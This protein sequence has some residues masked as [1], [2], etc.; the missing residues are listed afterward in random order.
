MAFFEQ[1]HI[2]TDLA[3]PAYDLDRGPSGTGLTTGYFPEI[4]WVG[5]PTDN[6]SAC[7][8]YDQLHVNAW[9]GW[10]DGQ[11]QPNAEGSVG[12]QI[13]ALFGGNFQSGRVLPRSSAEEALTQ[14]VSVGQKTKGYLAGSLAFS[15]DLE[16]AIDF[17]DHSL[18][19]VIN[20]LKA[21]GI[22]EDT[23]IIVASKHG[24][25]SI[26]LTKF[27]EIDPANVTTLIG[28]NTFQI[29]ASILSS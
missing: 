8:N 16:R 12:G 15:D 19:L 1:L 24:Q 7:T 21:K 28:V 14:P 13:P 23:L 6:V 9:L 2:A 29:T 11:D 17:V 26:D 18:G 3:Q 4:N 10:L 20:K 22:F 5:N 25:A 27:R